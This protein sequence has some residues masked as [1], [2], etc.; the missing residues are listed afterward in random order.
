L[1]YLAKAA[2]V[3]FCQADVHGGFNAN[4]IRLKM[5]E[6]ITKAKKFKNENVWVFLDEVNTSPDIGWFKEI[7]CDHSLDGIELPQ[8]MK[9][10][11]ACNPYRKRR[12][13]DDSL[14][15]DGS[16][17]ND[18][19]YKKIVIKQFKNWNQASGSDDPLSQFM[20]RVYPL[21]PTMKEYVF[22]FVLFL[23]FS[24]I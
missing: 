23:F 9:I 6:W 19:N 11:A 5:N 1:R 17:E 14:M 16:T 20:Y 15:N 24:G 21:P 7:V 13:I 3:Q 22:V 4:H 8:N 12:I 18:K 10:I 2:N